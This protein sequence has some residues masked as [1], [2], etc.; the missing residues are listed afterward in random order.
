M[1]RK[2]SI[3]AMM[4]GGVQK[5]EG[6]YEIPPL[7]VRAGV[8]AGRQSSSQ[9]PPPFL[10]T[11]PSSSI[12]MTLYRQVEEKENFTHHT[13][14]NYFLTGLSSDTPVV[15]E[16]DSQP[17]SVRASISP[18]RHSSYTQSIIRTSAVAIFLTISISLYLS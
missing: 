18:S 9:H 17:C 12:E 5:L 1:S 14:A 11:H 10:T 4:K 16:S 2:I 6:V 7:V 3:R 13:C 8:Q 15:E